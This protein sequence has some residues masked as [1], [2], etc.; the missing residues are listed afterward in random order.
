[1]AVTK[2]NTTSRK[3]VKKPDV[4]ASIARGACGIMLLC[5][6]VLMLVCLFL[7]SDAKML[8]FFLEFV[9][10]LAGS[11]C[12]IVPVIVM[13]AGVLL[14]FSS[15]MRVKV[16]TIACISG[17]ILCL[18]TFLQLFQ[19][20]SIYNTLV[21]RAE[22]ANYWSFLKLSWEN[23]S[24]MRR[25]GGLLGSLLAW[26][27]WR[28]F[29][30]WGAALLLVFCLVTLAL[31]LT[32]TSLY[33]IGEYFA[34]AFGEIKTDYSTKR[35]ERLQQRYAEEEAQE[36]EMEKQRKQETKAREAAQ[37]R[38]N[39]ARAKA[40]ANIPNVIPYEE[41]Q[42]DYYVEPY[43]D[44]RGLATPETA[45][46]DPYRTVHQTDQQI[47]Y[48]DDFYE[49]YHDDYQ[50]VYY[51]ESSGRR[52]NRQSGERR[53]GVQEA[54]PVVSSRKSNRAQRSMYI[55]P[56][57]RTYN[58]VE[59]EDHGFYEVE[60]NESW[61]PILV[62][63]DQNAKAKDPA[64]QSGSRRRA[65]SFGESFD[66]HTAP[67]TPISEVQED[68]D[69]A[70]Y[71]EGFIEQADETVEISYPEAIA[72]RA[73]AIVTEETQPTQPV[74]PI[75]R[76]P[77]PVRPRVTKP[78]N[79]DAAQPT[80]RRLDD[81]PLVIPKK[82]TT[83]SLFNTVE[84][85]RYPPMDLLKLSKK[86]AN[87]NSKLLDEQNAQKLL[88]TLASFGIQAKVINV[89]HG[90]AITRYELQPAPGVKVS[91]IVNLVDD[92]ALNMASDGVRIEA[93]IPGKPAVG[94]EIPNETIS[95]VTLR[96]VLESSDASKHDS[97]L[98]CAL[99]KDISGRNVIADLAKMPHVLIAGATGSGKSVCINTLINSIVFRSSPEEVRLILI[100]PKVVELSVY[101]GI[102]HLLIPV[103]T[104]PKKAS[105]ALTWAVMEM[106]HRYKRFA[107]AGV[108]DIRGY[109]ARLKDGET[110]MPKIV[111]IIDELADLMMVAPGEVEESICRLA[112]LARAAGIHLVIATQRPSV[113]VI[114]GV[115][116]ANIPSRI[117]FAVSSQIDS[118]T[119]LDGAGAEK[120]LGKGDMLYAPQ[121][122]NKPIR[123]QGCFVTDEEVEQIVEYI[124][125][126]G[127]VQ[128]DEDMLE[129]INNTQNEE[130]QAQ[131]PSSDE[132][133]DELLQQA[134]EIAVES[135]QASISMLQRRLR[136]GYAR[137]GRL[138]D[139][140]CKRGIVSQAEGAK[141]REVLI[142]KEEFRQM[143]ESE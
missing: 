80:N 94:I 44:D 40:E 28:G 127:D 21:A 143:F 96:D 102:P 90:P 45:Q 133:V 39:K 55:E 132:V 99:G 61:T 11:M 140:M 20:E 58:S 52:A 120:L 101:N 106:E 70:P 89:T 112:Q 16:R 57:Y 54:Q 131:Q 105:G 62:H 134:I 79:E 6:G 13:W 24:I 139:E 26:P 30:I 111:V 17:I 122:T 142:T 36:K 47:N 95:M 68:A 29:D 2:K 50:E 63:S 124:K 130:V 56:D 19:I 48:Q 91:R 49:D 82:E 42:D 5:L 117:A 76:T 10:G 108:R 7:P 110:A 81:T 116:K 138:V 8:K 69:P 34:E 115:I 77:S 43:E 60:E 31:L 113:N 9:Q 3:N 78:E 66:M 72:D 22:K 109:N 103:V 85:Y 97:T 104:D 128:Y 87:L 83:S 123:V 35:E 59:V 14:G 23:S 84:N 71:S 18:L 38:A 141:P 93:P 51:E 118:R 121:G 46:Y 86:N 15:K 100:D 135:G 27:L 114:T 41:Q 4:S 1:M 12:L 53:F 64:P 65:R 119:I 74:A 37:A 107:G 88:S 32:N 129:H 25:G 73:A 67:V 33:R 137:A 98:A 75:A 136:V 92:I 125:V 126:T